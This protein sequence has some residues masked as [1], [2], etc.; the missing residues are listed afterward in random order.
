MSLEEPKF[1]TLYLCK[2][3]KTRVLVT[4]FKPIK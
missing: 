3:E 4:S 1:D 2:T